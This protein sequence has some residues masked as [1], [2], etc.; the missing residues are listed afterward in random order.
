MN[1]LAKL[2]GKL[3]VTTTQ[4]LVTSPQCSFYSRGFTSLLSG[5]RT[6]A[7]VSSVLL[8]KPLEVQSSRGYKV[9]AVLKRR[10]S[11][12]YFEKRFGRMYVECRVKPRHKQMLLVSGQGYYRDDYSKGP[13]WKAVHWGFKGNGRLHKWGDNSPYSKVDWLEGRLGVDI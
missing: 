3:S 6:S 13:W 7:Q 11:G 2:L 10:C 9:K 12:C 1:N 8:V 4:G 5:A